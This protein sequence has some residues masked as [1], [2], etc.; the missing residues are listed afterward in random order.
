M[1]RLLGPGGRL[2]ITSRNWELV[3]S[4]GSR[5]DVRDRLVRRHGRDAVVSYYWHIEQRWEQEHVLEI[6]VARIEPDGAVQAC[7]ERLSL[8][9]YR[10]DDLVAQLGNVGLTVQSTTFDP[11]TDGYTVVAGRTYDRLFPGG[12]R[13]VELY[14]AEA[15]RH[16]GSVLELGSGTGRTLIPIAADGHPS[17]GLELSPDMLAEAQRKAAERGVDVDW[18]QGDMRDFDLGRRFDLVIIAA[19]SLLHLHDADDLVSCFRSVSRHLAAGA[20]LVFDVFN[21]SVHVLAGADGVR[22][23][24]EELAFKDP[25]RGNVSVD[26]A[27]TYDAA[28]QV[29]RG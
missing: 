1:S 17:V 5:V 18:V 9:P 14:R 11:A 8:W 10:Y 29:T 28:A 19:N 26:V 3:R 21:P 27:E 25:G 4:A 12:E 2:V 7:A 15:D 20:R 6:V 13:A 16:G 24:R 22:R 23:T